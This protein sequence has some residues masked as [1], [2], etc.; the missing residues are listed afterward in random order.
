MTPN[1]DR[2]PYFEIIPRHR[3]P[4]GWPVAAYHCALLWLTGK[5]N[6]SP[7]EFPTDALTQKRPQRYATL[8]RP[9]Y[10]R[11]AGAMPTVQIRFL[12]K[13]IVPNDGAQQ[14]KAATGVEIGDGLRR[15]YCEPTESQFQSGGI[16]LRRRYR[17]AWRPFLLPVLTGSMYRLQRFTPNSLSRCFRCG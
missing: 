5:R 12:V 10:R 9:S 17:R 6:P 4:P 14:Q 1:P 7:I 2:S 13:S 11:Q 16:R 3:I 15:F 8:L